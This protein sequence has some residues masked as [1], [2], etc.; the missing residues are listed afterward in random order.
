M[1]ISHRHKF[2]FIEVPRTASSAISAELKANYDGES[3]L[4]KHSNYA[5]FLKTA[6][7]EEKAYK[8]FCGI[9]NPLDDAVSLYFKYKT[10]SKYGDPEMAISQNRR[11]A[12][13]YRFV[14]EESASFAEYLRKFYRLTYGNWTSTF[15]QRIDLMIRFE[16]LQEDFAK[17]LEVIG[18][19]QVRELPQINKTPQKKD[20]LSA[21]TE[22]VIPHAIAIFGPYMKE[23]GY[24]L[25]EEWENRSVPASSQ[26]L[27]SSLRGARK[28]FWNHIR[29][30]EGFKGKAF[31][32]LFL[33]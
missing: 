3:R 28:V 10:R 27:Y 26:V 14:N 9:R 1:I 20:Y 5:S 32:S 12:E 30:D 25:P 17:M 33:R 4:K 19:E 22:D 8:V 2:L 6:N 13:R 11:H 31:R 7:E 16:H 18:V 29:Q 24:E 23:W 15:S 21:Y